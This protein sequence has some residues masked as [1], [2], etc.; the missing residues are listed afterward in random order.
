MARRRTLSALVLAFAPTVANAEDLTIVTAF[1]GSI[2]ITIP[3][4][5]TQLE[6]TPVAST[7][8]GDM[9][10][11]MVHLTGG[12]G[13]VGAP[14]EQVATAQLGFS[15]SL[16]G[17][18]WTATNN[19]AIGTRTSDGQ[20]FVLAGAR[21]AENRLSATLTLPDGSVVAQFLASKEFMIDDGSASGNSVTWLASV[22][23]ALSEQSD[24]C[25]P[26]Y[27][28]CLENAKQA[29][30]AGNIKR[31]RYSCKKETGEVTCEWECQ[32]RSQ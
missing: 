7:K 4:S 16:Q 3:A 14:P 15:E 22:L 25:T 2:T 18:T 24:P 21:D 1:D 27:N 10:E 31:F 17:I 11:P 23:V 9:G 20:T 5:Q 28:T 13:P 6:L 29:C 19:L 30:G 32:P 12:V 8:S 26:T